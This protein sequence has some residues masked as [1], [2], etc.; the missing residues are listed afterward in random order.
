MKE[1]LQRFI[2]AQESKTIYGNT[3]YEQ[4]LIEITYP[5]APFQTKPRSE[6]LGF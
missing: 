2:T 1:E 4:A 3:L 6:W 5:T